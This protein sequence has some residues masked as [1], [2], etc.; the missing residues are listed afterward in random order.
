M[1]TSHCMKKAVWLKNILVD[2]Q[3][4][5]EGPTSITC[6][7]QGRIESHIVFIWEKTTTILLSYR[8]FYS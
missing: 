6:D 8:P 2:I 7:N 4:V 1:V 3:Y 5:Q